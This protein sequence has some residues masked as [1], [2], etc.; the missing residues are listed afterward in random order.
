MS[1]KLFALLECATERAGHRSG[2]IEVIPF[3]D[4]HCFFP[5][6]LLR[7]VCGAFEEPIRVI[8]P[9]EEIPAL[10]GQDSE[11]RSLLRMISPFNPPP[12]LRS[13]RR[14]FNDADE[15]HSLRMAP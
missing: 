6:A 7:R 1:T 12:F 11:I 13:L 10:V 14:S 9:I 4:L 3:S 5:R 8:T 15:F 2:L